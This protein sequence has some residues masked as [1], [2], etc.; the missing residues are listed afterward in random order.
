V[1]YGISGY[2][3]RQFGK[4]ETIALYLEKDLIFEELKKVDKDA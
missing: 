1:F 2:N 4:I 3:H